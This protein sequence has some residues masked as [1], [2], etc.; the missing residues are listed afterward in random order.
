VAEADITGSAAF[1]GTK[2]SAQIARR[3]GIGRLYPRQRHGN[4]SAYGIQEVDRI[5]FTVQY[6]GACLD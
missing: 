2:D 5:S 1:L 6:D 3:D 4:L